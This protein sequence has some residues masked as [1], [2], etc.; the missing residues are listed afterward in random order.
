MSRKA[1]VPCD[2]LTKRA[3][4]ELLARASR[5]YSLAEESVCARL[6][7]VVERYLLRDEPNATRERIEKFFAALQADE[8][9]LVLACEAGDDG[10]WQTLFEQYG[11]TVRAA[12]RSHSSSDAAAEELAASIWAELYGLRA[13]E[14]GQAAGKL[15]FYSGCGSLGGWLRAVVSQLAIDRHRREARLVQTEED[16]D[17]DRL[18]N[19]AAQHE[20]PLHTAFAANPEESLIEAENSAHIQGALEQ[21]IQ[22]LAAQ[23]RLLIKLYYFDDLRLR[24]VGA[25]LGVHEATASRRLT[26]LH[27]EIRRAIEKIL[28]SKYGWT[29]DNAARTVADESTEIKINLAEAMP[30]NS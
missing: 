7:R 26:R 24:E 4:T 5:T 27:T 11:S 23:D 30:K 19:D 14:A 13:N 3:A 2:D 22:E 25:V 10:A 28:I 9:C 1:Q 18:S 29:A 12:A 6:A 8:L 20:D 15:A 17:W 21:A 16:A